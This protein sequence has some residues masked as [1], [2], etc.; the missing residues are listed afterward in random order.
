[1]AKKSGNGGNTSIISVKFANAG[2]RGTIS[3]LGPLEEKINSFRPGV[4][5][6]LPW[7][8]C[9]ELR[10]GKK[11]LKGYKRRHRRKGGTRPGL[12]PLRGVE[13][14]NVFQ[15]GWREGNQP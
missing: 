8:G 11:E 6:V 1:V 12:G 9:G 3:V 10:A 2:E 14:K 4:N 13:D 5:K 7:K 15:G